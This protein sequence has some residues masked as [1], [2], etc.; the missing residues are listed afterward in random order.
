MQPTANHDP[1]ST[2]AKTITALF[3]IPGQDVG[4]NVNI[5]GWGGGGADGIKLHHIIPRDF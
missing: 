3:P 2:S 1:I 4:E 5:I